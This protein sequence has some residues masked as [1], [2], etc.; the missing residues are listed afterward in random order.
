[1]QNSVCYRMYLECCSRRSICLTPKPERLLF[2]RN[3]HYSDERKMAHRN[4]LQFK[5]V[6]QINFYCQNTF[7][8]EQIWQ[9]FISTSDLKQIE[10]LL[11]VLASKLYDFLIFTSVRS[12]TKPIRFPW[13][14]FER[15]IRYG[16]NFGP[17]SIAWRT[18]W[19]IR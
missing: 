17:P 19:I 3:R 15:L 4:R 1:M 11:Q 12:T 16:N 8:V 10:T 9:E 6:S 7:T 5:Y 14:C 2:E 18:C 13:H